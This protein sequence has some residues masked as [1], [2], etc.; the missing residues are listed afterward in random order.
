MIDHR[1]PVCGRL[2]MKGQL[3]EVQ[4]KCPKCKK[5]VKLVCEK[6]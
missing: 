5:I 1:C 6:I 4:V 2:L 3:I